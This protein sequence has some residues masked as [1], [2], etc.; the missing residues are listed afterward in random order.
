MGTSRGRA[1]SSEGSARGRGEERAGSRA[2]GD[3]WGAD[4]ARTTA[5]SFATAVSSS[6]SIGGGVR[7]EVMTL[8]DSKRG[9]RSVRLG[10][11]NNAK[12]NRFIAS[13]A[14]RL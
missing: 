8:A 7:V 1:G 12:N 6:A 4:E 2:G 9:G 10:S 3:D 5:S 14:T 13:L 11:A